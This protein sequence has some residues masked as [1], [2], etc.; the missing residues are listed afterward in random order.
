MEIEK[1]KSLDIAKLLAFRGLMNGN[2]LKKPK[3][4]VFS[5]VSRDMASA[6]CIS[7]LNSIGAKSPLAMSMGSSAAD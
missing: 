4:P 6:I 7:A 5:R 1:A 3:N 2:K